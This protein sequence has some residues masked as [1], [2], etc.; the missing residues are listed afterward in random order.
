MYN[1]MFKVEGNVSE[2]DFNLFH[3]VDTPEEAV[4]KINEFY[5]KYMLAP[6]F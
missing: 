6:N 5:A 2:G 3:L 1:V 4:K